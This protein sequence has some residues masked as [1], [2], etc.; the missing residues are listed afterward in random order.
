MDAANAQHHETVQQSLMRLVY[1]AVGSRR[2]YAPLQSVVPLDIATAEWSIAKALKDG[3]TC[4][5]VLI[6]LFD[7]YKS[8]DKA[9]QVL[10]HIACMHAASDQGAPPARARN[11][12]RVPQL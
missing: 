4:E 2:D 7:D 11:D 8:P 6:A 3:V 9:P 12:R 5:A 10:D 1:N